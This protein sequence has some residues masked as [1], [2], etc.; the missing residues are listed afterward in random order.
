MSATWLTDRE[1]QWLDAFSAEFELLRYDFTPL[2]ADGPRHTRPLIRS[3]HPRL[4]IHYRCRRLPAI[5]DSGDVPGRS[6]AIEYAAK[7]PRRVRIS[8][9]SA[10]PTRW[11]GCGGSI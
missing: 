10:G 11:D 7:H 9:S 5:L 8:L 1:L 2:R 4:R 3:L 6:V